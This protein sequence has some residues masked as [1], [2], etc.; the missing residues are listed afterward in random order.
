MMDRPPM[1]P[2]LKEQIR[3]ATADGERL[4]Y[5]SLLELV[6]ARYAELDRVLADGGDEP[7]RNAD[8]RVV[9]DSIADAVLTVDPDGMIRYANR[10]AHQLFGYEAG[11]LPGIMLPAVLP[12]AGKIPVKMFLQ[13]Y[14]T[15]LDDTYLELET[16]QTEALR[17][18]GGR[19]T[20]EI[21]TTRLSAKA[22]GAFVLCLRDISERLQAEEALRENEERYR[23]LVDHATEAIVVLDVDAGQ[24]VD[25]NENAVSFFNLSRKRLLAM[26]PEGISPEYQLDGSASFGK[27]RGYIERAL[28]GE[29]PCFE[30]LHIDADGREIPCEVR[31]VRLPSANRKLLRGS[32]T[33]I[34]ERK[35]NELI[36]FGEHKVLEMVASGASLKST[37]KALC[38][39]V[40]QITPG[41]R[42]LV[43]SLD[44]EK[45][46]FRV[47]AS[48]GLPDAVLEVVDGFEVD[49][50]T[51]S[52]GR[53]V[54]DNT[55][56][57]TTDIASDPGWASLA[58]FAAEHGLAA[59]W[60][61]PLVGG[62]D[63]V[64]GT[65]ALYFSE[66]R[67]PSTAELDRITGLVRLAG[68]AIKR[69]YDEEA[70]RSS[71]A[72]F[73]GLFEHVVEGV[74]IANTEG[75]IESANP[76]LMQILGYD[77]EE[78]LKREVK[79][80]T[81][82]VNPQD[83]LRFR[84]KLERDGVVRN[85]EAR[86]KRRDGSEIVVLENSR[87]VLDAEGNIVAHEG[88]IT[89]I[90]ER[91]IAE[92]RI[93]EEKEKAQVTLKSIGDAVI[94]TDADGNVDYLNPVA[95]DLTGWELRAARGKPIGEIISIVHSH[96]R[97]AVDNPVERCLREGRVIALAE[98]SVLINRL[99]NEIPIQDSAAPIRDRV[100][101][102]IGA[103]MVFHDVSKE[104]RLSR[105][106][107]Y[108]A[109]HDS[110]TGL[111]NRRE[112]E[113]RMTAALEEASLDTGISH[114]L[115]YLDLDQFKVVND[116]FGHTAG[117]ELLR[118]LAE[119]IQG[120][121]RSSDVV[122][123]LGGD[124]Y[125]ILLQ[126]CDC[127][128][129][130]SVAETIRAAVENHRFV[131]QDSV[132][133]VRASVGVVMVTHETVS[134]GALMSAADVACYSA[135]D[136]G[137]NKVH[138]YQDGDASVRHR[139]M[140]WVSRI[141]SAV[142]EDR[143]ELYFQPI[144]AIGGNGNGGS[145]GAGNGANPAGGES[146]RPE[147][148]G[149][150]DQGGYADTCGHYELLLRMRDE[151][152]ELVQPNVFIPAAERFNLMPMLDRWVV[153]E[154]L[155]HLA[156]RVGV[157]GRAAYTLALNLSGTSLSDDRFRAWVIHELRRRK[158]PA[159]AI[160]F[161]ITET[162][163]IANLD[164]VIHFMN[165]LKEAGCL[166]SLD[167]FGSGLSSFTYL[168]HLPVDYLK[169]DGA[170]I[171]NVGED[172]KDQS[173]VDAISRIG[174][175]LGIAT[176]AERVESEQVLEILGNIG[177]EY[178]QGFHIARPESVRRFAPWGEGGTVA[179]DRALA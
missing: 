90:T 158:L 139:E 84:E 69:R 120:C 46:T 111:I 25:V 61:F 141:T 52:C 175:A 31:L 134:V 14:I 11:G 81:A 21:N 102:V 32:I 155:D 5:P 77:D 92:T 152:G 4:D 72:R 12:Q 177:V 23:A 100:G 156:D 173:L 121:I 86:M 16:G 41:A 124:E 66:P 115:L 85:F 9:L 106:L 35:R 67:E 33:S 122:A 98:D 129:A 3:Q 164:R 108:Q 149:Q 176:I 128:R 30:W 70:L 123:R 54:T 145:N 103:V 83:S 10:V 91:K 114:G 20:A 150:A 57:I 6:E 89:D 153:S 136:L 119:R 110:L 43:T 63:D 75:E 97:Q 22:S 34:A 130:V 76:A 96:S 64:L 166:F 48:T 47:A 82:Y 160:C 142:E 29:Q 169:I 45:A 88:T 170:F 53:A 68:I 154:T 113:N 65:L 116:T 172:R 87:A 80:S 99:S 42:V 138:L 125:G 93:F 165:D 71:E 167:D 58:D 174:K 117:D 112:F 132:Q 7:S 159:G 161:E 28:N 78:E 79:S 178:A 95:Q 109:A 118:Q 40:E 163:A 143:L 135:K 94:T 17:A 13:A 37:L 36:A 104:S 107:S 1:H 101:N 49:S 62:A 144:V 151:D 105:Q 15:N 19:F 74:Y 73:R 179:E 137:R 24:F 147:R 59:C 127:D 8:L 50:A 44:R 140:Q 162:A 18:D 55:Q 60:A 38:R 148:G 146:G 171:H 131:W 27:A 39:T 168:K 2:T 26:G 133:S 51:T 157:D 126:N 56:V